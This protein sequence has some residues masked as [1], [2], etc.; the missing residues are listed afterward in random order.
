MAAERF[1]RA[2]RA[3]HAALVFIDTSLTITPQDRKEFLERVK[4]ERQA[5]DAIQELHDKI[6]R[7]LDENNQAKT[8]TTNHN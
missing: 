8:T 5:Y 4:A 7:L 6:I 2:A 3:K 1:N